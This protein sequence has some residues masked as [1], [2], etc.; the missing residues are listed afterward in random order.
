MSCS[1]V[2][3][4]FLVTILSGCATSPAVNYY[5]LQDAE[6][7]APAALSVR[8]DLQ[9]AI[10]L[11]P[12]VVP[13]AIDRAEVVAYSGSKVVVSGRHQWAGRLVDALERRLVLA[14]Q[15][16]SGELVWRYP[17]DESARPARQLR[18]RLLRFGGELAGPVQL[19]AHWVLSDRRDGRQPLGGEVRLTQA[20]ASGQ[21]DYAGYIEAM[22][23]AVDQLSKAIIAE[24]GAP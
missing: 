1:R 16:H 11:W 9:N 6:T 23:A 13:D 5:R 14:L 2:L 19:H 15:R 3:V 22:A 10:G 4:L 21:G 7:K 8:V 17:W 18:V 12:V 24:V 20:V